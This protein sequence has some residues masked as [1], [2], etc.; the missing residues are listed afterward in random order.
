[1]VDSMTYM[2]RSA[3][4]TF[5]SEVSVDA[6]LALRASRATIT[7]ET[8]FALD[9]RRGTCTSGKRLLLWPSLQAV[10]SPGFVERLPFLL[11][12]PPGQRALLYVELKQS[13]GDHK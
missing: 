12:E 11:P 13:I 2:A 3:V 10:G 8:T 5:L 7:A 6:R 4:T 9:A 1:M